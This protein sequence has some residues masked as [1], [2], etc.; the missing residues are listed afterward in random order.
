MYV[1]RGYGYVEYETKEMA[2]AAVARM[3]NVNFRGSQLQVCW[4]SIVPESPVTSD[5]AIGVDT[6][7]RGG[8]VVRALDLRNDSG[9][10][11]YTRASVHQAV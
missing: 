2:D 8:V 4:V 7:L 9:Q 11:V 10:V 6:D 3:N 5:W 1:W